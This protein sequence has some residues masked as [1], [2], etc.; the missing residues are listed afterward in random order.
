MNII[1]KNI[2]CGSNNDNI[3]Q[4]MNGAIK[5]VLFATRTQLCDLN[6]KDKIGHYWTGHI[7]TVP[8][9][10]KKYDYFLYRNKKS[11]V[12]SFMGETK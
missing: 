3:E 1:F 11:I 9:A 10:K 5:A 2:F 8:I 4:V 12:C 6:C 7:V